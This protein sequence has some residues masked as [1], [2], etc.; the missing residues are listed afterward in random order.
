VRSKAEIVRE[1]LAGLRVLDIG[2]TGYEERNAYEKELAEAWSVCAA[3][4][5]VDFSPHADVSINLNALPLPMLTET[6]DIATAF[7][8]LEHIEH[9]VD[10]LRWIPSQRL[11]V[12]LPNTLSFI[13]RRMEEMAGV[14]H[15]FSFTPYTASMLLGEGGWGVTHVEFQ[16]GKWSFLARSINFFGSVCPS[17]VGTGIVLHC[18]R[19][20]ATAKWRLR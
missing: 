16:F 9:P 12:T 20:Q 4:I 14:K 8:V 11:I 13:T 15:L 1:H 18:D 10:V 5:C 7:D 19:N 17:R 2:G 6:Y 3:R